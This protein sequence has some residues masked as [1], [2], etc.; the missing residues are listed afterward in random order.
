MPVGEI[1]RRER[2]RYNLTLPQVEQ[3]LKI[4]IKILEAI[5]TANYTD[6][7]GGSPYVI[8]H[9]RTYAEYLRLDGDMIVSLLKSQMGGGRQTRRPELS[10]PIPANDSSAPDRRLLWASA[11]VIAFIVLGGAI[12]S[13]VRNSESI[14]PVPQDLKQPL[15]LNNNASQTAQTTT[16]TQQQAQTA[17]QVAPSAAPVTGSAGVVATPM[18][19]ASAVASATPTAV[20]EGTQQI[21][22]SNAV[23]TTDTGAMPAVD[24]NIPAA[25]AVESIPPLVMK[26]MQDSWME[27]RTG[28]GRVIYSGLLRSG[29]SLVLRE[30]RHDLQ[31]TTGNAGG[32]EIYVDG[33]VIAPLGAVGEVKKGIS[34]DP[35]R[36][37]NPG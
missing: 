7:T 13:S 32:I 37:K 34:L 10:M 27:V 20:P 33:Q 4:R 36:L 12:L 8:G 16:T 17:A 2:L 28:D 26:A 21:T 1:L 9:T 18:L 14:P 5:E 11:A 35:S 24:P 22:A 23:T 25:Q 3:D 15:T 6:I 31:L 19:P 29:K 30:E